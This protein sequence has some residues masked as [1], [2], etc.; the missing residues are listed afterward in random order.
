MEYLVHGVP[1]SRDEA[2]AVYRRFMARRGYDAVYADYAFAQCERLPGGFDTMENFT[3]GAVMF[4][5]A[6]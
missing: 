4:R 2:T 6:A 5:E 3:R 1:V